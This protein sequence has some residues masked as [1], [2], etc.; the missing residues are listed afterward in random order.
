[1][2]I[3]KIAS[4]CR[5][6]GKVNIIDYVDSDGVVQQWI[7]EGH[8]AYPATGMPYLEA[9][10]IPQVFELTKKQA[11]EMNIEAVPAPASISFRDAISGEI[12]CTDEPVGISFCGQH[13]LPVTAADETWL[14]DRTYLAPILA[15]YPEVLFFLRSNGSTTYFAIKAGL[16]L[17]G[18]VLPYSDT[19]RVGELCRQIGQQLR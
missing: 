13:F 18:I 14:I 1:M 3:R 4:I 2:K 12:Q 9:E 11:E 7:T 19:E 5:D 6:S 16:M 8:A 10:H 15:E 17:V